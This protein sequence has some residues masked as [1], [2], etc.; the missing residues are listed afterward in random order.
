MKDPYS[1]PKAMQATYETISL[2]TDDFCQA[3]LNDEYADMCRQMT[4]KLARKRPSPLARG[5]PQNWAAGVVHA[6]GTVNFA[7]DKSQDPHII[8]PD[9][10]AFFG[11]GK[12][13]PAAKSKVILDLFDIGL[14]DPDWTLPS[15]I[16]S[17]PMAWYIMVNGF[18]MDA[19]HAPREIQEVAYA[20]GLIPYIPD[21]REEQ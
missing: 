18:M 10:S 12:N 7:F 16:D 14:M 11:V 4:A 2:L 13:S 21:D 19:R 17:N 5:R 15:R 6:I 8:V 9:I 3:K 20:K 1:V